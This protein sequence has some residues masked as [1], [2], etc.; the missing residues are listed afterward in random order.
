MNYLSYGMVY[1]V[2]PGDVEEYNKWFYQYMIRWNE[3][4]PDIPLYSN[5]YYDVYNADIL[6]FK[7]S[8]FFGPAD[9]ILYCGSAS[10]QG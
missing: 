6:N 4:L 7:T 1:S 8:P 2:E 5:I 10:A 3:L 9:A